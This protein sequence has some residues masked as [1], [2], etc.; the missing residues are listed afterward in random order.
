MAFL[1]RFA[2]L[3]RREFM[4]CATFMGSLSAFAGNF[5]LTL[6]VHGAEAAFAGLALLALALALALVALVGRTASFAAFLALILIS[7]LGTGCHFNI[8]FNTCSGQ[9]CPRSEL[10]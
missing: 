1:A 8:P 4:G 7:V 10:S 9:M 5:A 3:F 2:G 6:R